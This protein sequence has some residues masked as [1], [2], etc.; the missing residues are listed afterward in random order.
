MYKITNY[1]RGLKLIDFYN[2]RD[3]HVILSNYGASIYEIE[4]PDRNKKIEAI[5]L[6][7]Q[8]AFYYRSSKYAGLSVG[9]VLGRI[10]KGEFTIGGRK[11]YIT[12]NDRGNLNH[13]GEATFAYKFFD[14]KVEEQNEYTKVIFFL[15]V[16]DMEDGFPGDLELKVNYYLYH[17]Q[18]KIRV[19]YQAISSKDTLLNITNHSYFNLSGNLK[20]DILEH[21]LS[22]NKGYIAKMDND[23]VI[24]QIE[25]VGKEFDFRKA[26]EI[27]KDIYSDA[28]LF[29]AKGYDHLFTG[30]KPLDLT[31]YDKESGRFLEITSNY[32]DVT[33][34]TNNITDNTIYVGNVIDSPY[35]AIA[36]EPNR[37]SKILSSEGIIQK[38]RTL[39]NYYIDYSFDV[40]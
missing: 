16:K 17:N 20:R 28:V 3:F 29:P 37:M 13:S 39:Y 33:I 12:P 1:S 14:F 15:N 19:E 23:L 40:R 24:K 9:R 8:Y 36:I 18:N 21:E 31:L 34:Y 11:Y 2:D 10:E 30:S 27:G 6:T 5:T 25:V 38:A 26:K 7:P 35:L 4:A 32:K 22:I